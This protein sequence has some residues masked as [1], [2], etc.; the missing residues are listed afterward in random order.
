MKNNTGFFETNED[1]ERGWIWNGYPIKILGGTEVEINDNKYNI[2]P[3]IRKVLV[4][5]SYKTAKSMNDMDKVV[6]RDM[7]TKT[8]YYDRIRRKVRLSGRDRYIKNNLDTDV[9]RI[10]NSDTKLDGRG[11]EK[12]IIPSSIIDIYTRLEVLLGLKLSG[13]TDTL[14][15]ASN[16]IDELYKR[17]EIQNKQQYRSALIKFSTR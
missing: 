12:I 10:L 4:D 11:I 6:F 15:E 2:T 3:G 16:L 9:R 14:T 5:S 13:H 1:P 8:N 7:S 17:G